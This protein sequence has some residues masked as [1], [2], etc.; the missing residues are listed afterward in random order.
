MTDIY[1]FRKRSTAEKLN[2]FVESGAIP[3][4]R[5]ETSNDPP[6]PKIT[7]IFIVKTPAG[8][9]PARI[10]QIVTAAD[11]PLYRLEA[12]GTGDYQTSIVQ[13]TSESGHPVYA[14]VWNLSTTAV[15]GDTYLQVMRETLS[16][17]ILANWEDCE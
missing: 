14:K 9:I 4:T 8:G 12:W 7:K 11:C 3:K 6:R 17:A 1:G 5:T 10:N 16:G 15:A 2:A 13:H